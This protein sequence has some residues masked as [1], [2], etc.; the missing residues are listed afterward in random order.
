MEQKQEKQQLESQGGT[1]PTSSQTDVPLTTNPLPD[2][3]DNVTLD[4]P[5]ADREQTLNDNL[6][7]EDWW[8]EKSHGGDSLSRWTA[9]PMTDG[10][11]QNMKSIADKTEV[12]QSNPPNDGG[13]EVRAPPSETAATSGS[14]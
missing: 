5:W 11:Y 10:P 9:Q 12:D 6:Q 8:K 1:Q 4:R 14:R 3:G 7:K 2:R 13:P